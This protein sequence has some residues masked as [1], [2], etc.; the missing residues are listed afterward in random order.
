MSLTNVVDILAVAILLY[1]FILVLRGRRAMHVLSGMAVLVLLYVAAVWLQL[2]LLATVLSGLA[3]YSI[4]AFVVMFQSELRGYLTRL[5]RVRWIRG[6]WISLSGR[7]ERREIVEEIMLAV[8]QMAEKRTG[9]LIVIERDI[10]LRTFIESG[11][12]MDAVVS[13]DLLMAIFYPGAQL[14]DGAVIIQGDRIAAAACFLPLHVHPTATKP[15]RFARWGTRHRAAIGV[16]ED[17]DALAVVVSEETAQI[18]IAW[19]GELEPD[20]SLDRLRE[21]LTHHSTGTRKPERD[22]AE[23]QL[24]S[25]QP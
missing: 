2:D 17:T 12:T 5:G 18:S 3:P 21:R 1:N 13:R 15:W 25:V 19:R 8:E 7:L 16:T 11:V 4:F 14:H 22:S 6:G 24:G 20:I 23:V 9:A 10:G